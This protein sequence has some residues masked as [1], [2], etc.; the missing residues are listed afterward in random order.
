MTE[1]KPLGYDWESW[2]DRQI[3]QAAGMGQQVQ[4]AH[5]LPLI[6][7]GR[8]LA[9]GT[10]LQRL[11]Q[12]R[13]QPSGIPF[14]GGSAAEALGHQSGHEGLGEG[15]DFI[16]RIRAWRQLPHRHSQRTAM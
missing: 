12:G 8:R 1:R 16:Q 3:R 7:Q 15:S 9:R 5:A 14:A 11:S 2:V 10:G 4:P 13:G 6:T